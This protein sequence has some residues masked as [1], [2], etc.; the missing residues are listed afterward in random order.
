MSIEDK[1]KATAKSV[2]GKLEAAAGELTG[3]T[4][5]KVEGQAKQVEAAAI[6][7]PISFD[8]VKVCC[9]SVGPL[10]VTDF[11]TAHLTIVSGKPLITFTSCRY[12]TEC[13]AFTM[14]VAS[15]TKCC[16]RIVLA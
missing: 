3:Y 16:T 5:M 9:T 7:A 12:I 10:S 11:I 1:I 13:N 15:L 4:Q 6:F 14:T 2:E 8:I